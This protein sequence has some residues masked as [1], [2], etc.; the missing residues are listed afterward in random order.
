MQAHPLFRRRV[1]SQTPVS[2][3]SYDECEAQKGGDEHETKAAEQASD[4]NFS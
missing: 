3:T 1:V 4:A 2:F